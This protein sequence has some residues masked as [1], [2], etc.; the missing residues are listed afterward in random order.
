MRP[1]MRPRAWRGSRIAPYRLETSCGPPSS[2]KRTSLKEGTN[3][4]SVS[5][6]VARSWRIFH[7]FCRPG[8]LVQICGPWS[9]KLEY[10]FA[11]YGEEQVG[12]VHPPP[13]PTPVDQATHSIRCGFEFHPARRQLQLRRRT[14]AADRLVV[15]IATLMAK[16]VWQGA[17]GPS[18]GNREQAAARPAWRRQR[19]RSVF[20]SHTGRPAANRAHGRLHAEAHREARRDRR[21]GVAALAPPRS[22]QPRA[23]PRCH[24][25]RGAVHA[26]PRQRRHDQR[27]SARA[28]RTPRAGSSWTRAF[29][30]DF[31]KKAQPSN[32]WA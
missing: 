31:A 4:Q 29:F 19:Q 9:V 10:R 18:A 16:G 17:P 7:K 6:T 20:A 27:L 1:S 2:D 21:D 26:R 3:L 14:I 32:G 13:P 22:W 23:R 11:Q 30:V 28:A 25:C 5:E 15:P 24:A 12:N 8:Y